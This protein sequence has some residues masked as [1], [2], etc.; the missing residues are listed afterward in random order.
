M[1]QITLSFVFWD[2]TPL[3]TLWILGVTLLSSIKKLQKNLKLRQTEIHDWVRKTSCLRFRHY[4]GKHLQRSMSGKY[5]VKFTKFQIITSK[6][7]ESIGNK[8]VGIGL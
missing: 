3:I 1:T 6:D 5:I 4:C 7:T 8:Q 2:E